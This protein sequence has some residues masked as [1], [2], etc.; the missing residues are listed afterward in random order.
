M[1]SFPPPPPPLLPSGSGPAQIDNLR[2]LNGRGKLAE[3][4]QSQ[5][6]NPLPP[7]QTATPKTTIDAP[8][9]PSLPQTAT[10]TTS[11]GKLPKSE[12]SRTNQLPTRNT[13]PRNITTL[14]SQNI[15][16]FQLPSPTDN[17]NR[18]PKIHADEELHGAAKFHN[19]AKKNN[20]REIIS[21]QING[22]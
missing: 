20:R 15:A 8:H 16:R 3:R 19:S 4:Q 21:H 13:L 22:N 5:Q 14:T 6:T 9:L 10:S 18:Y 12:I 2:D 11:S 7:H 1:P 17:K